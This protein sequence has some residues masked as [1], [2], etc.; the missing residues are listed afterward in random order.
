[1]NT[2]FLYGPP[3]SGKT[4]LG[5]KLAEALRRPFFDLDAEIA[6]AKGK[7]IPKIFEAGGEAAFRKAES[8]TLRA[9]KIGRAHV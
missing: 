9:L 1:M 3:A 7:S 5:K 6:K 8:E 4:T 2:L